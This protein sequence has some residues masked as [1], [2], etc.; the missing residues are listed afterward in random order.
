MTPAFLDLDYDTFA[1][2][3]DD[4]ETL[5]AWHIKS[6]TPARGTVLHFHGN[7]QNMTAHFLFVAWLAKSGYDVI[8]FDYRGYGSSSG[9]PSRVGLVVDGRAAIRYASEHAANDNLF[10]LAQSLGG[11]VAVSALAEERVNNLRGLVLESTFSSY[12]SM[13]QNRLSIVALTW[14]LQVPLSWMISNQLNPIE[15]I[16][17]INVATLFIVGEQDSIVPAI[18]MQPLID[19]ATMQRK[20]VWRIPDGDHAS[21][22]IADDSPY[23]QQ[24][25]G[26]FD[27]LTKALR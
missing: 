15:A 25:V 18:M 21:A 17:K 3:T 9:V 12:R 22:F 20:T 7:A 13:A 6:P 23:R 14:P 16:D 11:A 19:R 5:T 26:Y 4:R 10:I 8:T 1:I 27:E 2:T 24:L